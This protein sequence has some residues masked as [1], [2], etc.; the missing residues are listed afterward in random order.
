MRLPRPAAG[1]MP[2]I[3]SSFGYGLAGRM[4]CCVLQ[5]CDQFG[6]S[7]VRT[8]LIQGSLAGALRHDRQLVAVKL[9][10]GKRILCAMC[11][12]DLLAG[13]EEAL[14]SSPAI[15]EQRN[16]ARRRLEQ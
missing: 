12:Y 4:A 8:V 15:A 13:F 14:D 6:C 16:A 5:Q 9:K 3:S 2:H 1:T 11:Q 10:G 7:L